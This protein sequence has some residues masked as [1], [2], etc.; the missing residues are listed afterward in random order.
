MTAESIAAL[1]SIAGS[2][3]GG[4]GGRG[5]RTGQAINGRDRAENGCTAVVLR[6][7]FAGRHCKRPARTWGERSVASV[8]NIDETIFDETS[9][10]LIKR[11]YP[12]RVEHRRDFSTVSPKVKHARGSRLTW[13]SG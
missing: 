9:L 4:L 5:Q 12:Y 10:I 8:F 2:S 7:T 11:R 6:S 3:F 1:N 13:R